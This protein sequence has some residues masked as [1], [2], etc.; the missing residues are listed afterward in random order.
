M[1]WPEH[2]KCISDALTVEPGKWEGATLHKWGQ[3]QVRTPILYATDEQ[4]VVLDPFV[5]S[6]TILESAKNLNR[7]AIGIEIEPK[8]CEIAV[9]RLRQEVLAF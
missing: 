6:G 4:H 9:K 2:N 7:R 1:W 5:G 8:Y 3:G